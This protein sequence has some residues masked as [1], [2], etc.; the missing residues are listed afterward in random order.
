MKA[1]VQKKV[2]CEIDGEEVALGAHVGHVPEGDI[3]LTHHILAPAE[4]DAVYT[5]E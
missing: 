5:C 4:H 2:S 1:V 3:G